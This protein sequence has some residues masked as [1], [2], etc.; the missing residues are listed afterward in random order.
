MVPAAEPW[1][2]RSKERPF[3]LSIAS[4]PEPLI[5]ADLRSCVPTLIST[6]ALS[7]PGYPP[8]PERLLWIT[9]VSPRLSIAT[10][11]I[12]SG[13]PV[14]R[15]KGATPVVTATL[16]GPS[17]L[18]FSKP[19][20]PKLRVAAAAGETTADEAATTMRK[21]RMPRPSYNMVTP[22]LRAANFAG[23]GLAHGAL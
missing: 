4:E 20:T 5:Q 10:R 2:E 14:A 23:T 1:T 6:G 8:Q 12:A 21:V 13:V 17:T 16:N 19:V 9:S 22:A 15:A 18:I 11:S 3:A 7:R